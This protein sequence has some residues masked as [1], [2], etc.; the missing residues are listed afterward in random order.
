MKMA[1]K[2]KLEIHWLTK[3]Q[4]HDYPS[5]CSYL[6]LIY[7][8]KTSAAFVAELKKAAIVEFKAK[9]IFR[10]SNLSQLYSLSWSEL[11]ER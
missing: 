6:S 3:P 9:D 11:L 2:D 4:E 1:K 8:E 10:A 7:D 5:A